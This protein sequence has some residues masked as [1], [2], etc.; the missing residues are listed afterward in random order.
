MSCMRSTGTSLLQSCAKG[1]LVFFL[2]ILFAIPLYAASLSGRLYLESNTNVG[3]DGNDLGLSGVNI[4]LYDSSVDLESAPDTPPLYTVPTGADGTYDFT[5][6]A[7][8]TYFIFRDLVPNSSQINVSFDGYSIVGTGSG[9]PSTY[10]RISD[11]SISESDVLTGY[12][13]VIYPRA[14]VGTAQNSDSRTV[15]P[16]TGIWTL[17]FTHTIEVFGDNSGLYENA[18]DI[19]LN[20]NTG[21]ATGSVLSQDFGTYDATLSSPGTYK[22]SVVPNGTCSNINT[23]FDL[24]T[25]SVLVSGASMN[26]GES[27]T[28]SYTLQLRPNIPDGGG[29]PWSD[30]SIPQLRIMDTV[31]A[32][33]ARFNQPSSD[34]SCSGL[35][36]DPDGNGNPYDDSVVTTVSLS[37]GTAVQMGRD[38]LKSWT[39]PQANDTV[40]LR[41]KLRA[42]VAYRISNFQITDSLIGDIGSE[43]YNQTD[44]ASALYLDPTQQ[45]NIV[46]SN[47]ALTQADIDAGQL[48][49]QATVTASNIYGYTVTDVSGNTL[50][51]WTSNAP[52]VINLP[53][54]PSIALTKTA[55]TSGLSSPPVA[56]ETIAYAITVTNDGNLTLS[57]VRVTDPLTGTDQTIATLLPGASQTINVNYQITEADLFAETVDNTASVSADLPAS[58]VNLTTFTVSG[59]SSVSVPLTLDPKLTVSK[60]VTDATSLDDGAHEGDVITYGFTI[61]NTGNV[62]LTD[63]T[64]SETLVDATITA[65]STIASLAQGASNTT[66]AAQYALKAADLSAG[67][68]TN[69]AQVT[70]KYDGGTLS[71]TPV[72]ASVTSS[73]IHIAA[74]AETTTVFTTDGGTTGSVLASDIVN[75]ATPVLDTDVTI[76]TVSADAGLTLNADGTLTLASGLDAGDYTLTYEICSTVNTNACSQVTETVTQ[77]PLAS[78]TVTKA[79]TAR[80]FSGSAEVGETLSY[81]FTIANTGNIALS[82]VTIT[83]NLAGATVSGTLGQS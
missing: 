16:D 14:V 43:F 36:P 82:D 72:D 69:T 25:S 47:Y 57:N 58:N 13:F 4:Y 56:G 35:D 74:V 61:T 38:Y 76:T 52:L 78:F 32:N 18:V 37:A 31:S 54:D 20:G 75:G 26:I 79:E 5:G 2:G 66:Y 68:V 9:T 59:T 63:V 11:V 19:V 24:S 22:V 45:T 12:D 34:Y 7:A 1:L 48:T 51:G 28:V 17:E 10:L 42:G 41:S 23:A 39:T 8:G 6:V 53:A 62:T 29:A 30:F 50:F 55:D 65:G 21:N 15:A 3:F 46:S 40:T 33:G 80:S 83:E 49:S 67:E 73:F 70:A 44:G 71:I 60:S 81:T 77:G 27:C 64:L